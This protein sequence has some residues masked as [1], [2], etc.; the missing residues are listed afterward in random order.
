MR[1][2]NYGKPLADDRRLAGL[3]VAATTLSPPLVHCDAPRI[4]KQSRE[5]DTR[6]DASDVRQVN[7]PARL[8]CGHGTDAKKLNEKPYSDAQEFLTKPF[9]DEALEAR[10]DAV[11]QA[12]TNSFRTPGS[13]T[14]EK[15]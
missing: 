5:D 2:A 9:N 6:E 13:T 3:F 7:H 1:G 8:D 15:R 14:P 10:L 12:I 11:R 4:L